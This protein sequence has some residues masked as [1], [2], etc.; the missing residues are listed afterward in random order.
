MSSPGSSPRRGS[1][2]RRWASRFSSPVAMELRSI[3]TVTLDSSGPPPVTSSPSTVVN[4]HGPSTPSGAVRGSR[5][6]Y[7][8]G[9]GPPAND[10]AKYRRTGRGHQALLERRDRHVPTLIATNTRGH[11]HRTAE[12]HQN[13]GSSP[14][15]TCSNVRPT[16]GFGARRQTGRWP[17]TEE[18]EAAEERR[19]GVAPPDCRHHTE[20]TR[21]RAHAISDGQH[22]QARPVGS[23]A[24]SA[25]QPAIVIRRL[26]GPQSSVRIACSPMHGKSV[27]PRDESLDVRAI[28]GSTGIVISEVPVLLACLEVVEH[29]QRDGHR[30]A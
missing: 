17:A 21:V 10:V 8:W 28:T 23:L 26:A 2:E 16:V 19:F 25:P 9:R 12:G 14:D 11:H 29:D 20:P 7:G 18:T 30:D 1:A 5:P 6:L 4:R 22:L 3:E 24:T 13:A 15:V 27:D